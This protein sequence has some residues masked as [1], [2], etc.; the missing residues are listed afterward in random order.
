MLRGTF[1]GERKYPLEQVK[2]WCDGHAR[3]FKKGVDFH[4]KPSAFASLLRRRAIELGFKSTSRV[5]GDFLYF[6]VT[7]PI[8]EEDNRGSRR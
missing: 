4:C 8:E 6:Q 2:E 7:G 3:R 5:R 1:E